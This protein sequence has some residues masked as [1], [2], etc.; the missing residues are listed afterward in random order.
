MQIFADTLSNINYFSQAGYFGTAKRRNYSNDNLNRADR[1]DDVIISRLLFFRFQ[2]SLLPLRQASK[3]DSSFGQPKRA[4]R[5]SVLNSALC[6]IGSHN[7]PLASL[8]NDENI[9]KPSL[10]FHLF[11]WDTTHIRIVANLFDI[12]KV[13]WVAPMSDLH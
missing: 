13:A 4:K 10:V 7:L 2:S 1:L 8:T 5:S 11:F 9:C 3:K 6:G 12:V